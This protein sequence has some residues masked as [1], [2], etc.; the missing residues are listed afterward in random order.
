[1]DITNLINLKHSLS[2]DFDCIDFDDAR[3]KTGEYAL[4]V[5]ADRVFT[6]DE[7]KELAQYKNVVGA[8]CVATYRPDPRI[9]RSYFYIKY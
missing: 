3:L 2:F 1:M 9:R 5:T 6:D 4:R 7:V 8:E